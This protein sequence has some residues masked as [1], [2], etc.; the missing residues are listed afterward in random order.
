MAEI[1]VLFVVG[2]ALFILVVFPEV[3]AVAVVGMASL[4]PLSS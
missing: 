2:V 4:A 1:V 3:F